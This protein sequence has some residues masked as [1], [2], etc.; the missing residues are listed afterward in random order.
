MWLT[1]L[2]TNLGHVQGQEHDLGHQLEHIEDTAQRDLPKA[3]ELVNELLQTNLMLLDRCVVFTKRASLRIRLGKIEE[4]REDLNQVEPFLDELDLEDQAFWY[5]MEGLWLDLIDDMPG[6]MRSLQRADSACGTC[7][8]HHK[9]RFNMAYFHQRAKNPE[10]AKAMYSSLLQDPNLD[11]RLRGMVRINMA[12]IYEQLNQKDSVVYSLERALKRF[13]TTGDKHLL[14]QVYG[15]MALNYRKEGDLSKALEFMRKGLELTEQAGDKTATIK[16]RCF[17]VSILLEMKK[18]PEA[19]QVLL[20]VDEELREFGTLSLRSMTLRRWWQYYKSINNIEKALA[21]HERFKEVSDSLEQEMRVESMN[22]LQMQFDLEQFRSELEMEKELRYHAESDKRQLSLM[23]LIIMIA[24]GFAISFLLISRKRGKQIEE[25]NNQLIAQK[26]QLQEALEKINKDHE[27]KRS[28]LQVLGHDL[29]NP[30][31]RISTSLEVATTIGADNPELIKEKLHQVNADISQLQDTFAN[32]VKWAQSEE[33]E[34]RPE[35]AVSVKGLIKNTLAHFGQL[36]IQRRLILDVQI[37]ERLKVRATE[38]DLLAVL[39]NA[40]NNAL[41]YAKLRSTISIVAIQH[42]DQSVELVISN[43]SYKPLSPELVEALNSRQAVDSEPD[44]EGRKGMGIGHLI[45]HE[46]MERN[47][48][49]AHYKWVGQE[50]HLHLVFQPA[51]L[52]GV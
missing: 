42:P 39:R 4:A 18:Y 13:A 26:E 19:Y 2:L 7:P 23:I 43:A 30:L 28:V 15:S 48:G 22:K 12:G 3:E 52:V 5:L 32:L 10:T 47:G 50:V 35:E 6:A 51:H 44:D 1:L 29:G 33:V 27:A 9:I 14:G 40:V 24:L 21:Y 46:M 49:Q 8:I 38:G 31:A 17:E 11:N 37:P 41:R 16:N 20:R 34:E 36:V 45:I 25:F